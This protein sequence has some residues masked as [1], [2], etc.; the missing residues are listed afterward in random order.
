MNLPSPRA[1]AKAAAKRL[2]QEFDISSP[3]RK[4]EEVFVDFFCAAKNFIAC[5]EIIEL[6]EK[7]SGEFQNFIT[8]HYNSCIELNIIAKYEI[9]GADNDY[10][11]GL[12]FIHASMS[13]EERDLRTKRALFDKNYEIL[14]DLNFNEFESL[15][16]KFLQYLGAEK[17]EITKSSHDDGID[18]VG[19]IDLSSISG[20]QPNIFSLEREFYGYIVGQAKHYR[21]TKFKISE[22]RELIGSVEMVRS[23]ISAYDS[24]RS[25][26]FGIKPFDPIFSVFVTSGLISGNGREFGRNSGV[27]IVDG[28]Q[29]T[30]F[31]TDNDYFSGKDI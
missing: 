10:I 27:T 8:E 19:R 15:M 9:V 18:F 28:H 16:G 3:P 21:R 5:D 13:A 24:N 1:A 4:L 12:A 31:L 11:R 22:V 6:C 20:K 30:L 25:N 26:R 17:F 23:G 7:G 29:L 14:M 2:A